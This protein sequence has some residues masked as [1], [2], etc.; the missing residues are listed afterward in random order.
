MTF[1]QEKGLGVPQDIQI[2]GFDDT[3]ASRNSRPA[4]TTVHQDPGLRAKT[5]IDCL[6]ALKQGRPCPGRI[7]L[8]VELMIRESTRSV[9]CPIL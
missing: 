7:T 3:L 6:E 8:P 9:S 1:F 4:L 2:V 5:A